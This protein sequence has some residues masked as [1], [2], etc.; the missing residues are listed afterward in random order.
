MSSLAPD[1]IPQEHGELIS[2]VDIHDVPSRESSFLSMS[3]DELSHPLM[4]SDELITRN[5]DMSE[6]PGGPNDDIALPLTLSS[7]HAPNNPAMSSLTVDSMEMPSNTCNVPQ[8]S[9]LALNEPVLPLAEE[10][11]LPED[12]KYTSDEHLLQ[13]FPLKGTVVVSSD[14]HHLESVQDEG[15]SSE[16]NEMRSTGIGNQL[17]TVQA[18]VD[19]IKHDL[20]SAA[21]AKGKENMV[22]SNK[23]APKIG[24]YE[25]NI[26]PYAT[27]SEFVL[28]EGSSMAALMGSM[29]ELG[30]EHMPS[31]TEQN[32]ES[33]SSRS[34]SMP[35]LVSATE[36]QSQ[37]DI[38]QTPYQNQ[39]SLSSGGESMPSSK[40]AEDSQPQQNMPSTT[41]QNQE[42]PKGSQPQENMPSTTE[43][44]QELPKSSQPQAY[45][46][47]TT[48]QNQELP[49]DSQPQ[50]NKQ[51]IPEQNQ[52]SLSSGG[53]S[54]PSSKAATDSQPQ[55]NMPSTTKQ[56]QELPKDSQP[57]ENMQSIP[58]QNQK[59]LSSRGDSMS[60]SKSATESQRQ[61]DY[62]PTTSYPIIELDSV[63]ETIITIPLLTFDEY[64]QQRKQTIKSLLQKVKQ[65]YYNVLNALLTQPPYNYTEKTARKFADGL[66]DPRSNFS[67]N[68]LTGSRLDTRLTEYRKRW[69][70][71][72]DEQLLMLRFPLNNVSIVTECPSTQDELH[73]ESK[74]KERTLSLDED[75]ISRRQQNEEFV[76][77]YGGNVRVCHERIDNE[78]K[79]FH[80][81]RTYLRKDCSDTCLATIVFNGHGS[82]KGLCVDSGI[83]I[84]LTEIIKNVQL[85]MEAIE[86]RIGTIQ[87]PCAV[88][89]VFAQCFGHRHGIPENSS[90]LIN[91]ISLAS[92]TKPETYQ[93]IVSSK[94]SIHFDLES[95]A[96]RRKR[97]QL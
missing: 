73:G 26:L 14:G 13:L 55:E 97:L 82:Q 23:N 44:N 39:E 76:R 28:H 9:A 90:N 93:N 35:L 5:L 51:S 80:S 45:M 83:D 33:L 79:L 2:T 6:V 81:I 25:D 42:L 86:S 78:D 15:L 96:E 1:S 62:V 92:S 10:V 24:Q 88:D 32:H 74:V 67:C 61:E 41:E 94:Q 17:V 37:E 91:V 46:P 30:H 70:Q 34:N 27:N 54:M 53:E 4:S 43:Q 18:A 38:P 16:R 69:Q 20:F 49:K 8:L 12:T 60:S 77:M 65:E 71:T 89:I 31:T 21:E 29:L 52:E 36:S 57:Q 56:N 64:T 85:S 59:S 63:N 84:P 11:G 66:L 68:H 22:I 95:Y 40:A 87:M 75:D 50:E 48:K 72:V 58:K 7:F 3:Q 47:S 19:K